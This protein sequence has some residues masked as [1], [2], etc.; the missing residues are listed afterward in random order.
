[1]DVAELDRGRGVTFR[2]LIPERLTFAHL[3]DGWRYELWRTPQRGVG[4]TL[5]CYHDDVE[6]SASPMSSEIEGRTEFERRV[7]EMTR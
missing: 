1:M 6:I 5:Y 3:A 4:W 2:P 7:E